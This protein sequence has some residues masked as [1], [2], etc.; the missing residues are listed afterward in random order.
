MSLRG[1]GALEIRRSENPFFQ[2]VGADIGLTA[3]NANFDWK[4]NGNPPPMNAKP[5][6]VDGNFAFL[7]TRESDMIG[8]KVN[9]P[10]VS[11]TRML[12]R[13]E[14]LKQRREKAWET[15]TM[16]NVPTEEPVTQKPTAEDF[17][18]TYHHASKEEDPRYTTAGVS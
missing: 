17:L 15:M 3:Q 14:F 18:R 10:Q 12:T 8:S 6:K 11:E 9:K 2:S 13:S 4:L 1:R 5:Y 7:Y 16:E